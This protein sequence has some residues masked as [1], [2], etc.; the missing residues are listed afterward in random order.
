[1]EGVL[2]SV[3][4]MVVKDAAKQQYLKGRD[5]ERNVRKVYRD[6]DNLS[7]MVN[8]V[9]ANSHAGGALAD[10]TI[11]TGPHALFVK[12]AEKQLRHSYRT[13]QREYS[14]DRPSLSR[15]VEHAS[16]PGAEMRLLDIGTAA[17]QTARG[18]GDLLSEMRFARLGSLEI[19]KEGTR[20][21]PQRHQPAAQEGGG[22]WAR[23]APRHSSSS[24]DKWMPL[25]VALDASSG[26]RDREHALDNL[27]HGIEQVLEACD[28]E[29]EAEAMA[30]AQHALAE[31]LR[32][33]KSSDGLGAAGGGGCPVD[34]ELGGAVEDLDGAM[35]S[36]LLLMGG[37]ESG[38]EKEKEKE[39]K[40]AMRRLGRA[41]DD[42]DAALVARQ[43]YRE[44]E[45]ERRLRRIMTSG[46]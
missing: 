44:R 19:E 28:D 39:K 37:A 23:L 36:L 6:V 1:M 41:L 22:A 26:Y 24:S 40:E 16:T 25:A 11:K 34:E 17:R 9:K 4:A 30:Y 35:R 12:R 14:R 32:L 10:N 13:L 31:V 21:P 7:I 15:L 43:A 33:Q 38:E 8:Q 2:W 27:Q 18:L 5:Y 46:S 45:G 3:A 42:V 29:H 20:P